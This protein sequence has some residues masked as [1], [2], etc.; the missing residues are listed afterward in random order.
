MSLAARARL[1]LLV[2]TSIG[3]RAASAPGEARA[4][5]RRIASRFRIRRSKLSRNTSCLWIS[6]FIDLVI[7]D[8]SHRSI[9]NT[10]QQ[11]VRY[12]DASTRG[13]TAT[14]DL[15][16]WLKWGNSES[17]GVVFTLD[18]PINILMLPPSP[19]RSRALPL[20]SIRT[21]FWN[22]TVSRVLSATTHSSRNA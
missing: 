20:T 14:S 16:A 17:N 15:A 8:Q 1:A 12:F 3:A 22:L 18:Y 13:L 21:D 5:P 11:V 7:A 19:A 10:Y 9:Y 6:L 2:N 4:F